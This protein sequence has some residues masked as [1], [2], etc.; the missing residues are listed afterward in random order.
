MLTFFEI[1]F[2]G[3][4]QK[5]GFYIILEN[6][7]LRAPGKG[8]RQR[9]FFFFSR[10]NPV[11]R[12]PGK[13]HR[14]RRFFVLKKILCRAPRGTTLGKAGNTQA[15]KIFPRVAERICQEHSTQV[16]LPTAPLGKEATFCFIFF[17]P[18]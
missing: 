13:G 8:R 12:A 7:L 18:H 16:P 9:L 14:Q 6:F 10:K 5:G 3:R 15:G 1:F 4:L 11:S 17:F 2:A